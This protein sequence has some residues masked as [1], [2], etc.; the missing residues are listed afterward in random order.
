MSFNQDLNKQAQKVACS[1]KMKKSFPAENCI[2]ICICEKNIF[3][4]FITRILAKLSTCFGHSGDISC[5]LL[6]NPSHTNESWER[7]NT[8]PWIYTLWIYSL[9]TVENTDE[10][11]IFFVRS[12][13][14]F[15]QSLARGALRTL[16]TL[17]VLYSLTR[18]TLTSP[19]KNETCVCK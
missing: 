6:V 15:W 5:S 16:V 7:R 17:F 1:R 2:Y 19:G 11:R 10:N 4:S 13:Q 12:P 14:A 18:A 3:C 9:S 8:C